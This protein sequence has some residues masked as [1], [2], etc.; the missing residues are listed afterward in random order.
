MMDIITYISP[1]WALIEYYD[2]DNYVIKREYY[3]GSEKIKQIDYALTK[4]GTVVDKITPTYRVYVNGVE[5]H[6]VQ[7]K[8]ITPSVIGATVINKETKGSTKGII[9]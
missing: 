1:E 7:K 2:S 9:I 6:T 5:T 3:D 4:A 8:D